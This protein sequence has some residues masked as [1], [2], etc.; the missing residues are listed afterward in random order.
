MGTPLSDARGTACNPIPEYCQIDMTGTI[1]CVANVASTFTFHPN[2][3]RSVLGQ[4]PTI[5]VML[6]QV[7]KN[8]SSRKRTRFVCA[9]RS[10]SISGADV[11][12]LFHLGYEPVPTP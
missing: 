3:W 4:L 6:P 5:S 9:Q 11:D 7:L 10:I 1:H 8:G 2:R 12:V